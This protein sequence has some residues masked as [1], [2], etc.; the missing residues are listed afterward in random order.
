MTI[1]WRFYGGNTDDRY[2]FKVAWEVLCITGSFA[3]D[4]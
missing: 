1:S 2:Q 3:E 4:H